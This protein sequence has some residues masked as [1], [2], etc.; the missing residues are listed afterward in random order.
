M[1]WNLYT[2]EGKLLPPL[3]FSNGKT[4]E[5]VVQ[6]V[7]QAIKDGFKV[8]FIK[9]VCGTGKSAIAL[10]IAKSV[11]KASIVVPVRYLQQQYEHD[12][13]NK[14]YVSKDNGEKLN[15]TVFTGRNNHHCLYKE[16]ALADDPTLPCSVEIKKENLALLQQYLEQNPFVDAEDFGSIDD[17]RRLSVAP[18][19]P[20]WSPVINKEWFGG[21]YGLEDAEQQQYQAVKNQHYTWYKRKPGCTY[22][23]QFRSYIHADVIV[24]NSKKYELENLMN[25]KPQTDLEIIDECDE[26]LDNF[27]NEKH[28]NLDHLSYKLNQ[29]IGPCKEEHLKDL[30]IEAEQLVRGIL[31][32]QQVQKEITHEKISLLKTAHILH[33]LRLFSQNEDLLVYEDL[34]PLF[35]IAKYFED[36]YEDSYVLYSRNIKNQIVVK[37]VNIN[38]EKKFKELLDK[39]KVFVLMSGTLHS[40]KVLQQIYGI[41]HFITIDAETQQQGTS[42][43]VFTRL[44]KNFRYKSFDNGHVTREEYL[45]ALAKSIELAKKPVLVHVNSYADLPTED[46][47]NLYEISHVQSKE[48]LEEQ[49]QRYKQGELLQLFKEKKLDILYSTK[50]SRGVDLPG[51]LCNSIVFTKYPYPSMHSVFWKVLQ[52]SRPDAFLDFYFDK[53]RREFLQ[54]IYRGLRSKDD[55]VR[56][57]SPDLKVLE[58]V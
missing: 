56:I 41:H 47:K 51:E 19:C 10:H 33:L 42:Q 49:Q 46:E 44:E 20:Y 7:L 6:E 40:K 29:L 43:R 16:G 12:Y 34:E 37:L 55:H 21:N 2:Q 53:A 15:I 23:E 28:I 52:L 57:L 17:I 14:M 3:R 31:N 26:F 1:T 11:G 25:R 4:Q 45:P 36:I 9:G 35:L 27:S 5:D 48:L 39:N 58:S 8:I 32:S 13:M 54:R 50:C 24:F 22:Y 18:A 38:L 30:L